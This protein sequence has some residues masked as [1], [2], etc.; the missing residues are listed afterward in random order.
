LQVAANDKELIFVMR[1]TE[2][3]FVLNVLE[4]ALVYLTELSRKI[5]A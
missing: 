5:N 1:I 3:A 4:K 2:R